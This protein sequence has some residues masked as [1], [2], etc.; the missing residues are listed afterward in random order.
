MYDD[1]VD[2]PVVVAFLRRH[3]LRL[4]TDDQ[5]PVPQLGLEKSPIRVHLDG[6]PPLG[7]QVLFA[8]LK[9]DV[10]QRV[11]DDLYTLPTNHGDVYFLF[12]N[13]DNHAKIM[14]RSP[15]W[16]GYS[17]VTIQESVLLRPNDVERSD[18]QV[19]VAPL[20]KI[21]DQ[22]RN[23]RGENHVWM[24]RPQNDPL[25]LLREGERF[26]QALSRFMEYPLCS[27]THQSNPT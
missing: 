16:L 6:D 22:L 3:G 23:V 2:Y 20:C 4:W 18:A 17:S 13:S 8:R 11:R 10:L 5:Q 26:M 12:C 21:A 15:G 7:A 14:V 24:P 27:A 25:A 19:L 1:D 9:A